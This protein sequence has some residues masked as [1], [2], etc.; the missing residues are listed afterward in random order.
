MGK[1][2]TKDQHRQQVLAKLKL[3]ALPF[4]ATLDHLASRFP[5][6]R[7]GF[8]E[9]MRLG[10]GIE[11][12]LAPIVQAWDDL[13]RY[14]RRHMSLDTIAE[15]NA[16]LDVAKIAGL[17]PEASIRCG[18]NVSN[19]LAGLAHPRVVAASIQR[20]LEPDGVQDWRM[21]FLHSGFLLHEGSV[22]NVSATASAAAQSVSS[23]ALNAGPGLPPFEVE[24]VERAKL[25]REGEKGRET[26]MISF[27]PITGSTGRNS[28]DGGTYR[29]R[30]VRCS[31][32]HANEVEVRITGNDA[33]IAVEEIRDMT[34]A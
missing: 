5:G 1:Y 11:P 7:D 2:K 3:S 13:P 6:G 20:A 25:I 30:R 18:I 28:R 22:F 16:K 34:L 4:R 14:K 27:P 33:S 31:R 23:A 12:G 32:S 29:L 19:M 24:T 8:V 10:C 9:M 17:V 26:P 21:Q 15:T